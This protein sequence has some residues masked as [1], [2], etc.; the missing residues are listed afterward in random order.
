MPDIL[1]SLALV[2]AVLLVAALLSGVIER[3]PISF[4]MIFLGLGFALGER[5]L[6]LIHLD[7]HDA[8]LETIATLSL[9]FVLFLDALNLEF[10]RNGRDWVIPVLTLGPGTLLTVLFVSIAAALLL[11]TSAVYSLLIGG[12]LASVDPVLLREVVEDERVP[13]AIRQA[14][15]TEAGA[16]D[17]IALP[18]ILVLARVALGQTGGAASWALLLARLFLLGPLVG[19]GVGMAS[20]LLMRLARSQTSVSREYRALYGIGTVLVAYVAGGAVGGSGFLAVFAA[21]LTVARID[22]D[23]CDCFLDYGA[24]TAEMTMLLAF[25]LFGALLSTLITTVPLLP[26]LGLALITLAVA[27]PTAINLVLRHAPISRHGRLFIGW[28]GP[29]G[30][31]SLLFGLLLVTDGVPGAESLLAVVGL[32]V[33]V[34]TIAHGASAAPLAEHYVRAVTK[35]TLPEERE[36]TGSGLFRQAADEVPRITPGELARQLAG[37]DPPIVLD[38]RTRSSYEHDRSQIPGSTRVPPGDVADWAAT[39]PP[40]RL[41]VTYCT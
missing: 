36:S 21:G 23:I 30:L 24:A 18:I 19:A 16:N 3:I 26:A 15:Q 27:R 33:I 6:G 39:Q 4:P 8:G 28:F 35:T 5:G 37:D 2:G 13:R 31:S 41:I 12:V 25:V 14:L 34:S 9:A 1:T 38:V 7:A 10:D 32:V 20:V 11:R 22:Y 17:I 29:R 40:G